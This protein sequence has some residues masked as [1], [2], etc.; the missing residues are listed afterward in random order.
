M[1]V[2]KKV[3]FGKYFGDLAA[4]DFCGPGFETNTVF[5]Y[6]FIEQNYCR[7]KMLTQASD[8][9]KKLFLSTDQLYFYAVL[10]VDQEIK[11]D[12]PCKLFAYVTFSSTSKLT[13]SFMKNFVH[14]RNYDTATVM[15]Y[16][17]RF[18][19]YKDVLEYISVK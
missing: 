8:I 16:M 1:S 12:V 9:K 18:F 2:G 5:S 3:N 15:T 7:S 13:I 19:L 10:S 6:L 17:D 11:L 4:L 14:F